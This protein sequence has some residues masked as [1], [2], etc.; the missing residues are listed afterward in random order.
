MEQQRLFV[1]GKVFCR[2]VRQAASRS[3]DPILCFIRADSIRFIAV[4]GLRLVI[5]WE[6]RL[7]EPVLQNQAFLVPPIVAQLLSSDIVC[8]QVGVEFVV[9]G[10]QVIARLTDHLGSYDITWESDL[11]SF[12]SPD[13]FGQILAVPS[14]LMPVPYIR[15]SDAT[16][17]AV[18]NLVRIESDEQVSP[19][20]LAIL[21]DLDFG[22][23]RVNGREII[24]TESRQ[25]YFDPR[26]VIRALEFMRD[27][28]LQVG[29]T[30]L[31]GEVRAYLSL[32]SRDEDW[33]IHCSLLSIGKDTQQLYPLPHGRDR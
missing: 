32:L 20:K 24:A 31:P 23:L 29:I 26:L 11:A 16:H 17:Q 22:R 5:T 6:T 30:P 2:G 10:R 33:T 18:A 8:S 27:R 4:S 3:K 19:T 7:P 14:N 1:D 25:Y 21:I 15:F 13:A 12:P 9:A 28:N